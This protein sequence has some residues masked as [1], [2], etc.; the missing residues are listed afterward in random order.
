MIVQAKIYWGNNES[1][2]DY[3]N[4]NYT[5][6]LKFFIKIQLPIENNKNLN[7]VQKRKII[8]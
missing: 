8:A 5:K 4:I 6:Q 3:I 1:N 7:A 2:Y